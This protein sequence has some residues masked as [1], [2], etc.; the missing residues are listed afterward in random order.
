MLTPAQIWLAQEPIDMRKGIDSLT[1]MVSDSLGQ[2]WQSGAAFV[3]RNRSGNRVKV[4]CWDQHGVWICQRRLH[5]GRFIWPRAG[6]RVWALSQAQFD[7]L[8]MGVDWQRL[9]S[10]RQQWQV[11]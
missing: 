3:F 8:I 11:F 1:M 9:S 7:W 4:L 10:P 6:D 5:Q 2:S